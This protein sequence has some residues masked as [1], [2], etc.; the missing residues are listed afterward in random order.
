MK[1]IYLHGPPASGKYTIASVLEATHGIRNFHNHLTIDVSKAFF[2]FG[3]DDFWDLTHL[4]RRTTIAAVAEVGGES[5]VFTNCYSSPQDDPNVAAL[6]DAVTSRGGE[7]V[8]VFL[9]CSLE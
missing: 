1:L 4:L 5:V 2:E 6:E 9:E 8:P 7:F 3:T